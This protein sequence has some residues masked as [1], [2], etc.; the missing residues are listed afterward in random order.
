M[1]HVLRDRIIA[2][3]QDFAGEHLS[4]YMIAKNGE[5][6]DKT[7]TVK[8][9]CNELV[10]EGKI[11]RGGARSG[12]T[13]YVMTEGQKIAAYRTDAPMHRPPLKPRPQHLAIIERLR[14]DRAATPSKG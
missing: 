14:A 4:P 11:R 3:L 2:T 8:E 6:F 7:S 10:L 5:I 9:V 1:N 13:F 12:A